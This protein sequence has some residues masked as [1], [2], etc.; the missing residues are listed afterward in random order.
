MLDDALKKYINSRFFKA[1][2]D[3][4]TSRD[5]LIYDKISAQPYENDTNNRM[6]CKI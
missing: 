4:F 6:G 1:L 2:D 3:N 5:E